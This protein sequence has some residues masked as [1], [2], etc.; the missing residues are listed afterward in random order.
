LELLKESLL[1]VHD[2]DVYNEE[3]LNQQQPIKYLLRINENQRFSRER[4]NLQIQL[5]IPTQIINFPIFDIKK[6]NAK[7]IIISNII[8]IIGTLDL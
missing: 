8:A 2:L 1:V 5:I 4:F 7:L 6:R 3:Q